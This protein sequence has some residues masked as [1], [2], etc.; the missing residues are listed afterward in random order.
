MQREDVNRLFDLL[1][2]LYQGKKRPRDKV[3]VA[4]W[5]A[6]LEPWSYAQVRDG[7][8]R[9]ARENRYF[10]DPSEIVEYL[11]P[12]PDD[13]KAEKKRYAPPDRVEQKYLRWGALFREKLASALD[14]AGIAPYEVVASHGVSWM[15]W[16]KGLED[17]GIDTG[18][19]MVETWNTVNGEKS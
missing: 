18:A 9:R 2:Q 17:A 11:P 19:L 8:I 4:I 10:P 13:D 5:T 12:L 7:V 16:V 1:E 3:T 15:D 14:E 6:V